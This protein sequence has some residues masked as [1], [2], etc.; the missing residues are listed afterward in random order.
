M[1]RTVLSL[2][3]GVIVAGLFLSGL[4]W[5]TS[6]QERGWSRDPETF[7]RQV[8]FVVTILAV[9]ITASV[10]NQTLNRPRSAVA[11][12]AASNHD[13]AGPEVADHPVRDRL[14]DG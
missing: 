3:L 11:T 9:V 4:V 6:L 12:S 8:T 10:L 14:L 2:I 7:S 5:M 13:S 1:R